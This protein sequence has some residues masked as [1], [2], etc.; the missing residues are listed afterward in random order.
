MLFKFFT[1]FFL[2]IK[3]AVSYTQDSFVIG[4]LGDSV[5][6]AMNARSWGDMKES[7]WS[8]GTS[9]GHGVE[10]HYQK[11]RQILAQNIIAINV[12][13]SGAT[14]VGLEAQVNKLLSHNPDYVTLLIG[15]NDAC[16]WPK[17][18][19]EKLKQFEI[20]IENALLK[21]INSNPETKILI[22]P[23]P[24]MLHLWKLGTNDCQ[25]IWDLFGICSSLLGSSNSDSDRLEFK[26]RLDD[27]NFVYE[28][29]AAK[30]SS[31]VRFDKELAKYKFEKKDVSRKDC[32]HPSLEG[33]NKIAELTW[34]KSWFKENQKN[35]AYD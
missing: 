35:L 22:V 33:Q 23:V 7:N 6:T 2:L 16:S 30:Y 25:W 18:H 3:T 14:S 27:L 17:D 34:E 8:T 31:H 28:K 1:I 11:L 9:R 5:T 10:S 21:L 12:A 20:R 19:L 24:D 29:L 26:E 4:S 15:A 32:F 13:D